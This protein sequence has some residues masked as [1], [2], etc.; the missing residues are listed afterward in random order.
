MTLAPIALFSYNRPAHLRALLEALAADPLAANSDLHIYSDG[1]ENE[2]VAPF[3][4]AVR[5]I[6]KS[7]SGF[8]SVTVLESPVNLGLV[9][10]I[11]D[12]VS[13]LCRAHGRVIVLEDDLITAPDFLTFMNAALEKYRDCPQVMQISGYMYPVIPRQDGRATFLPATSC[14]GWAT[15]LRAWDTYDQAMPGVKILASDSIRRRAFNLDGAY[16]YWQMLV[17]H[18][19]G[20]IRSWGVVW[21]LSVFVRNGLTLYP[22]VSL[23]SNLGFDG[24]GTHG[25]ANDLGQVRM[26]L[27][28]KGFAWPES[29]DTDQVTYNLVK[30]LIRSSKRG[31]RHWLKNLLAR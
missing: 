13:R 24:S 23:V 25:Q 15:W 31:W 17:D 30:K 21:H 10:A 4:D 9:K 14:W 19:K 12:G 11:T 6:A 22:P 27:K 29:I 16:D 8:R 28:S 2:A 7:A 26:E 5:E 20:R 3:V 18:Q 1:P